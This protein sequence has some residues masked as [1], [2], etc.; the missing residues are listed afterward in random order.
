MLTMAAGWQDAAR[1]LFEQV[2]GE[3]V[4]RVVDEKTRELITALLF[5]PNVKGEW[6]DPVTSGFV[7]VV[8]GG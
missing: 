3:S 8:P 7:R 4:G 5:C 2:Y 6:K 1:R